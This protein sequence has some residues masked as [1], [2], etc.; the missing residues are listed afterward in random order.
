MTNIF[1][2]NDTSSLGKIDYYSSV[3]Y[4]MHNTIRKGKRNNLRV[5]SIYNEY[6]IDN[7]Q[8]WLKLTTTKK[9]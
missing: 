6:T 3:M 7:K 2:Q 5:E 9:Q 4:I 1:K 8:F